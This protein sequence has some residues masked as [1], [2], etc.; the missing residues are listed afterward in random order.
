MKTIY[1]DCQMGAAGD[2]LTGALLELLPDP[3][4]FLEKLNAAGIPGVL[5]RKNPCAAASPGP[6]CAFWFMAGRSM[7]TTTTIRST[8]S[9]RPITTAACTRSAIS[10]S[11]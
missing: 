5:K 9:M 10:W 4:A 3:A 8:T 2:M 11:I 1:I 7:N 6:I